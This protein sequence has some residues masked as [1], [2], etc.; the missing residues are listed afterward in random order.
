LR[1][2]SIGSEVF[3]YYDA[4]KSTI[5]DPRV[6]Q[7]LGSTPIFREDTKILPLQAADLLVWHIR[8]CK[9]GRDSAKHRTILDKLKPLL[10]GE[11]AMG[12][13]NLRN[14]AKDLLEVP[15]RGFTTKKKDS[16]RKI[17]RKLNPHDS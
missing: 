5:R 2:G 10:H 13:T 14:M 1:N 17:L 3:L 9:E 16:V 4:I 15:N 8:R 11:V 12:E 7:L 6:K